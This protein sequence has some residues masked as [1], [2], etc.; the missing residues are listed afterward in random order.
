MTVHPYQV[1]VQRDGVWEGHWVMHFH[2]PDPADA[3]WA[4]ENVPLTPVVVKIELRG[5]R[6]PESGGPVTI[7]DRDDARTWA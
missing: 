2:G 6:T 3:R 1:W 7:Y 5:P 4:A